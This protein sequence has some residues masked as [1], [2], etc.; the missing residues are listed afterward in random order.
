[1]T[2]FIMSDQPEVCRYCG[3]RTEFEEIDDNTQLHECPNC[4]KKYKLVELKIKDIFSE[5]KT[6]W[7]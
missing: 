2:T 4:N 6:L 5:D 1:M 7:F 3:A